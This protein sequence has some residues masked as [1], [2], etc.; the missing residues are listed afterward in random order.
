MGQPI[1][2]RKA[3]SYGPK[4]ADGLTRSQE[5]IVTLLALSLRYRDVAEILGLKLSNV[6]VIVQR[7]MRRTGTYSKTQLVLWWINRRKRTDAA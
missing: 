3:A 6:R 5:S 7:A 4:P 1:L 2:F